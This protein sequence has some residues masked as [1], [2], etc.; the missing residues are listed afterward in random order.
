MA[1]ISDIQS[2]CRL[3]TDSD[4]TSYT[5]AQLL[6]RINQALEEVVSMILGLDGRWQF[7]D[8]NFS[9]FPIATTT[10]VNSQNDY[11]FDVT[12]LEIERVEVLDQSGI[13]H[14]V[15]P[16]DTSQI[17][18]AITEYYKDD[19]LPQEYDKQGR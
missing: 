9:S 8:T 11:T 17:G 12:H 10:L 18:E 13:W 15:K 6:I 7:D 1:S 14:T 16:I 2:E 19:G 5:N 4:S 3:L